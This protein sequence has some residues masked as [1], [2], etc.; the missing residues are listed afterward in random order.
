MNDIGIDNTLDKT[1]IRKLLIIGLFAG[2]KVFIGDFILG[3]GTGDESLDGLERKL[4]AYLSLSDTQIF[5]SA[6]LG[7]IGIP[8]EGLCYF[9]IYRM[10]APFSEKYA[11][12][13]RSGIFG[14]LIF[15]GCGVH[16][17]CLACVFFY[18]Y[19]MN[20]SPE[21]A[22]DSTI[23]FGLYFLLPGV[24]MFLIFFA[25]Q[26]YAHIAAF[27]KGLTPYP[28][29]CWIFCL[30][31]GMAATMILK[32]F[33]DVAIT[34]ALTAAWISIGNIWQFGGLLIMMKKAKWEMKR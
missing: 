29:W 15:G 20:V 8:L 23:K 28:K 13:Y 22:Y 11:H 26:S 14:Y 4:S 3:Y 5:V 31:V 12:I 24:V 30:P 33:G 18:K 6:L 25:V 10:I 19:M 32:L 9:A 7:F 27:V 21:T 17:P 34:N 1:R 2:I 16:V